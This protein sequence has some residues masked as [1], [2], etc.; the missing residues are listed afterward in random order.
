MNSVCYPWIPVRQ[1]LQ[2]GNPKQTN[3]GLPSNCTG[4]SHSPLDMGQKHCSPQRKNH[5]SQIVTCGNG[6]CESAQCYSQTPSLCRYVTLA[7]DLFFV[8]R[9]PFFLTYSQRI[10]FTAVNHLADRFTKTIFKAYHEIHYF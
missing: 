6:L 1:G 4:H 9:I 8:N 3:Q 7:A 5:A 2:M 10:C